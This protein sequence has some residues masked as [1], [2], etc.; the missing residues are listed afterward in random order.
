M[1]DDPAALELIYDGF[2][3]R[4]YGYL[5]S[6]LCSEEQAEEVPQDLFVAIAEKRHRI[7]R[8]GNLTGYLFAMARNCAMDFLRHERRE[9]REDGI[10]DRESFLVAAGPAQ[11]TTDGEA[12]K[13]SHALRALPVEQR[14]VICMKLFEE[15]TFNEIAQ[16]LGLSLNTVASRYR[17][18]MEK[19]RREMSGGG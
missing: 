6:I 2:G 1:N 12:A 11:G 13:V 7:A 14:E 8:A 5:L 19:L 9:R 18:G 10:G 16:T 15:L 3:R 17:Y 4:L